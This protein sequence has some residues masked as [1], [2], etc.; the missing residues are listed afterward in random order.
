M[1]LCLYRPLLAGQLLFQMLHIM[2]S[3]EKLEEGLNANEEALYYGISQ[4]HAWIR[5]FECLL[6]ISYRIDIKK[7]KVTKDL[8]EEFKKRK[9]FVLDSLYRRNHAIL[10]QSTFLT[11]RE[12]RLLRFELK[13]I[14]FCT[15]Y[16]KYQ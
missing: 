2:N 13:F 6:H 14:G 10:P 1:Y 3:I 7:W 5:F 9:S 16:G 15:W 8:K 12:K 11:F 4:L